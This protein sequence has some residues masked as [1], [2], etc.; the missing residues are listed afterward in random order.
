[1][2]SMGVIQNTVFCKEVIKIY[3]GKTLDQEFVLQLQ[4]RQKPLICNVN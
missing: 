3:I 4:D 2:Y 1:M